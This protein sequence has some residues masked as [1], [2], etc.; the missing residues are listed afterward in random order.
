MSATQSLGDLAPVVVPNPEN[1]RSDEKWGESEILTALGSSERF[2]PPGY[3]LLRHVHARVGGTRAADGV[4]VGLWNS[5]GLLIHGFEV[6]I[7]RSDWLRE[8]KKPDKADR[9]VFPFCD[10]WWLVTPRSVS[11]VKPGELP[12]PWGHASVDARG[13]HIEKEAPE[14]RPEPV[15]RPFI[16]ELFRRAVAQFPPEVRLR[17]EYNRGYAI[18]RDDAKENDASRVKH[19]EEQLK[20]KRELIESFEKVLG[21][22]IDHWYVD[23]RQARVRRALEFVLNNGHEDSIRQLERVRGITADLLREIDGS[24]SKAKESSPPSTQTPRGAAEIAPISEAGGAR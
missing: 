11:V 3:A 16:A 4:A 14:L 18:G 15:D 8:L 2:G 24:L 9:T 22:T 17:A 7:S 20:E 6:K 12:V 13:V 23:E 5:R 19:L 1:D 21:Q 10:R